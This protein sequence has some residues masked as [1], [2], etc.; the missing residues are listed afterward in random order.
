[1]IGLFIIH[2]LPHRK[3][4]SSLRMFEEENFT[5]SV[6]WGVSSSSSAS[7][8]NACVGR[9]GWFLHLSPEQS[10]ASVS[11]ARGGASAP[12]WEPNR[13]DCVGRENLAC[14]QVH[15]KPPL[16]LQCS[17]ELFYSPAQRQTPAWLPLLSRRALLTDQ[18]IQMTRSSASSASAVEQVEPGDWFQP[19]K[20][21]RRR[22]EVSLVFC[23]LLGK[24]QA[25]RWIML[26]SSNTHTYKGTIHHANLWK[27][28]W[29]LCGYYLS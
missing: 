16:I 5:R 6:I 19:E 7:R 13:P 29:T 18:A 8:L 24:I 2:H 25:A 14:D 20:L 22:H 26:A 3:P 28:C 1:M 9:N 15:L 11:A 12:V 17:A 10:L 23:L 27:L 4:L 21:L